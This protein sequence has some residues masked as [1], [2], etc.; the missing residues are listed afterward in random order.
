MGRTYTQR[1]IKILSMRSG[2][3]CAYPNCNQHLITEASNGID[4]DVVI[5]EIAHIFAYSDGGPRPNP[6]QTQEDRNDYENL[7]FLCRNHHIIVD[8]QDVAHSVETLLKWKVAH[9]KRVATSVGD[10]VP[11]V[12]SAELEIVAK[13]SVSRVLCK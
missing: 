3:L 5:G 1:T 8:Q 11:E 2:G 12:T 4:P 6:S 13:A 9:E 10:K 7:I